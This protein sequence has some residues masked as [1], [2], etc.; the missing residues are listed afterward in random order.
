MEAWRGFKEGNWQT[1]IDVA[2]FIL[3]N[4]TEYTGDESFLEG[5]TENTIR[6]MGQLKRKIK[7][8]KRKGI[9]DVGTKIPSKIDVY[10]PGYIDK[11]L[12]TIVGLQTDGPLKEQYSLT[13]D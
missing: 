9:Y 11:D 8:W 10:G 13:V 1:E 4:Y 7:S 12:E 3:N 2:S 6:I 5:P